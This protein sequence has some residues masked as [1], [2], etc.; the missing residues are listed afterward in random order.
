MSSSFSSVLND[1]NR[2]KRIIAELKQKERN[3]EFFN[4]GVLEKSS[5][6]VDNYAKTAEPKSAKKRKAL[7]ISKSN[8]IDD[9][10]SGYQYDSQCFEKY[11]I[12]RI[13]IRF[14]KNSEI[15]DT[16]IFICLTI[17]FQ[18]SNT[19]NTLNFAYPYLAYP[20]FSKHWSQPKNP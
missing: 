14:P 7:K 8:F 12:S 2:Q 15:R 3:L 17:F 11:G 9:G 5:N 6:N 20:Y 16:L 19:N 10:T 4:T 18:K 1:D 13:H